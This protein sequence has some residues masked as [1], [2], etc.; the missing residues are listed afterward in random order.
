MQEGPLYCPRMVP[1]GSIWA[2]TRSELGLCM[3]TA[4]WGLTV[5]SHHPLPGV[6]TSPFV[7][8]GGAGLPFTAGQRAG[9]L[10]VLDTSIDTPTYLPSKAVVGAGA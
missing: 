3:T 6:R 5:P 1:R 2:S 7:M 8:T 4:P 9:W 10:P